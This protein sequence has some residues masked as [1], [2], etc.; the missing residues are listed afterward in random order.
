MK[1]FKIDKKQEF[2]AYRILKGEKIYKK[3][4]NQN[5][6]KF[7][8]LLNLLKPFNSKFFDDYKI[9]LVLLIRWKFDYINRYLLD[10][11]ILNSSLDE[12]INFTK[13]IIDLAKNNWVEDVKLFD[14]KINVWKR[15]NHGFNFMWP[16]NTKGNLY[17]I[18]KKIISP[19]VQQYLDMLPKHYLRNSFVLDSG[20]GPARYIN[21]MLKEKPKMI[22]GMDQGKD[23]I[24]ANKLKYKK[25]K[26]ISFS[27]G[28]VSK[29]NFK[30]NFFDLVVSSGVLH[31]SKN[32]INLSIKEHARVI[33]K[34]GYFFVF[35]VGTGGM[36]LKLWKFCRALLEDVG[37]EK[38]YNYLK[39][40]ISPLRIQGFLDH[41]FGEYQET[42]RR[43]FEK[44]LKKNFSSFRRV[45][46]I[47][48]A[49]CTPEIYNKDKFFKSRF[50]DGDLRYLCKK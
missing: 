13:I 42:G 30:S 28:D 22:F 8:H 19:R 14:K 50:G 31:H 3:K 4:T 1:H 37:I 27:V 40:K 16:R 10:P 24:K 26:K 6:D 20:C 45:K 35:I 18:S 29:L 21:V 47:L 46:G 7:K 39:G 38:T 32:P 44:I 23:I 12:F 48:G 43:E 9:F 49:D 17:N 11:K 33:K 15:T 5:V 41:S 2:F 25:N 36:Q 34:N